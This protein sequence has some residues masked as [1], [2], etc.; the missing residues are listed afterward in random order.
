MSKA[1]RSLSLVTTALAGFLIAFAGARAENAPQTQEHY[2]DIPGIGPVP[3]PLPPGARVFNPPRRSSPPPAPWPGAERNGEAPAVE[4]PK[5]EKPL[6]ALFARLAGAESVEEA[7]SIASSIGRL[8]ARSGS[9]TADLLLARAALAASLRDFTLALALFDRI[10]AL[11]PS[12]P[13]GFVGRANARL[14]AGDPEGAER[15]FEAAV[16]LE[17]RRFDALGALAALQERAG[18][19]KRALEAYRRALSLD[20]R[21]DEWRRAEERLRLEVEGRDI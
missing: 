5:R 4:A 8:W 11:E 19:P 7:R 12:W 13:E 15:D 2:L 10:V 14:V 6:D 17:P 1:P 16:R 9:E 18:A 20:P 3:I 21:R